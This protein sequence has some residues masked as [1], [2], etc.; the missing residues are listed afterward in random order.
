MHHHSG[1]SHSS[2]S[3]SFA[4]TVLAV[5]AFCILTLLLLMRKRLSSISCG[6]K[7]PPVPRTE[8]FFQVPPRDSKTSTT[9][10]RIDPRQF[11]KVFRASGYMTA[12]SL[13]SYDMKAR[14]CSS[15]EQVRRDYIDDFYIVDDI[16]LP[17][18][19]IEECRRADS[20]VRAAHCER[21]AE[22]PWNIAVSRGRAETGFPHTVEDVICLPAAFLGAPSRRTLIHEKIHVFQ[23][24]YPSRAR[25][26]LALMGY[27][28]KCPAS[29]LP[30]SVRLRLRANP[31]LDGNVYEQVSTGCVPAALYNTDSRSGGPI[32]SLSNVTLACISCLGDGDDVVR[33]PQAPVPRYEHPFEE[34]AYVLAD[35]ILS[36]ER[37]RHLR[38]TTSTL[39]EN[40]SRI[41]RLF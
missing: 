36:L 15:V 4:A 23:R 25:E 30:D 33:K 9:V 1:P 3:V 5:A 16:G 10:R 13:N 29:D 32:T 14:R 20:V 24:A 22:L 19:F 35:A 21:L 6:N 31:D 17:P 37:R 39:D 8:P 2:Y 12:A 28:L 26:A 27:R 38:T 40:I 18:D 11:E 41:L 7:A 34:M